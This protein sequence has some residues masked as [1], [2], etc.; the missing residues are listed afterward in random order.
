MSGGLHRRDGDRGHPGPEEPADRPGLVGNTDIKKGITTSTFNAVPDAPISRFDLVLPE[1]P[2]S[3]LAAF[4]NLCSST[5]KMPTVIS[6][7]NGAV[8]KQTTRIAVAGCPKHKKPRRAR[9]HKSRRHAR[10]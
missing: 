3:A 10:K 5:L 8:I 7:Q 9:T 6:G 1:G 2:H 4:G